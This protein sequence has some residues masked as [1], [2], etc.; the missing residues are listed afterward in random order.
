MHSKEE[1]GA[2]APGVRSRREGPAL[3]RELW[4]ARGRDGRAKGICQ[5]LPRLTWV[6]AQT[7]RGSP[8]SSWG[9]Q[10]EL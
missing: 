4:V 2:G 5:E 1:H 8:R 6:P 9:G 7:G 3:A 10:G